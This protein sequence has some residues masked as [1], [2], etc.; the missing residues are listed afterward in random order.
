MTLVTDFLPA[1]TY[2]IFVAPQF[3]D[4]VNCPADYV[5]SVDC[6]P[7]VILGACCV[8]NVCVETN[9]L[10]DCD[11]LGGEWFI[12]E[13]C[14]EFLCFPHQYPDF[15]V[16]APYTSPLRNTCEYSDH[17]ALRIA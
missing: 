12:D 7:C 11:A 13:T 17:C 16:L 3:A 4:I 2:Y 5:L 10:P 6:E 9:E 1:G 14:P 15:F 8:D